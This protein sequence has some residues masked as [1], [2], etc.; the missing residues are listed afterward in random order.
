MRPEYF[1]I[2]H[3]FQD[4]DEFVQATQAWNLNIRQLGRGSF[5][6]NLLQ[7][8][9]GDV[10]AAYA[11]FQPGTYQQGAPPQ[12][13][14][15]LCILSDPSSHLIWR[16]KTIPANAVMAFPPGAELDAVSTG[17]RLEVFTFSFSD[18]LLAGI[19]RLLGFLDLEQMLNGEDVITVS[20]QAITEIRRFLHRICRELQKNPALLETPSIRYE[21]EFEL[22]RKLLAALSGSRQK[23]PKS[24]Y[25][26]R[27]LALR[28]IENYLAEFPNEPHTVRDICRVANVSERTLQY[29]FR[30]R[31][32]ISPKSYL[33]ALR[34]NGIRRDLRRADPAS[35]RITD[36]A[37]RWGFW[38][39]SQFAADYRRFFGELPSNTINMNN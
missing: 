23:M 31:F 37:I 15:T 16:R 9:I 30:E 27:D 22:P 35:T 8:G 26:M 24:K 1:F 3:H 29:A 38:H 6:G 34:L 39:M 13:L 14:R 5:D 12:G 20:P 21:L 18:E 10:Q 7:F 11:A 32:G 28:R 25:R 33:M 17:G 36:L 19:S 2:R 4:F